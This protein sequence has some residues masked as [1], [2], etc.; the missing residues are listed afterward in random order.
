MQVFS[1]LRDPCDFKRELSEN[2]LD[3]FL[4]L[5]LGHLQAVI[6]G[7]PSGLAN[8]IGRTFLYGRD[9]LHLFYHSG[10]GGL[11]QVQDPEISMFPFTFR[12]WAYSTSGASSEIFS[13]A[14]ISRLAPQSIVILF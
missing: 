6:T 5:D 13:E 2:Y 9:G 3:I 4:P 1:S 7:G 10:Q 14:E 11:L 8:V 12:S